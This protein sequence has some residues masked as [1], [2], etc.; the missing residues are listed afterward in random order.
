MMKKAWWRKLIWH[1]QTHDEFHG[2]VAVSPGDYKRVEVF[3]APLE[4]PNLVHASLQLEKPLLWF[5]GG[6]GV[7]GEFRSVNLAAKVSV[8]HVQLKRVELEKMFRSGRLGWSCK[9]SNINIPPYSSWFD[10]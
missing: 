2:Q 1:A 3:A 7:E 4:E 9:L 6:S 10:F 5:K 8:S